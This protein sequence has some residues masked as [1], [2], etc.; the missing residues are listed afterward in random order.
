MFQVHVPKSTRNFLWFS[1]FKQL[2]WPHYGHATVSSDGSGFAKWL[3]FGSHPVPL[4]R[5]LLGPVSRFNKNRLKR[6]S[7][8]QRCASIDCNP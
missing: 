3:P 2:S 5:I 6:D 4:K 1:I 8:L 7:K